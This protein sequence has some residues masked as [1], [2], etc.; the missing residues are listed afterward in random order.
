MFRNSNAFS[1]YSTNDMDA[2]TEFYRD[3]L[4][5]DVEMQPMS[6]LGLK[7]PNGQT[8]Y[9]YPK[10]DA[11]EPATFTVLNFPVDDIEAAVDALVAKGVEMERYDDFE[12]DERGIA[13]PPS[14]DMGPAIAWFKDPAGNILA[15]LSS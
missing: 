4:G 6:G 2:T 9:I 15:V 5:L 14:R 7:F 11:H 12:Q 13:R 1:G 3:T 8:V 10:G